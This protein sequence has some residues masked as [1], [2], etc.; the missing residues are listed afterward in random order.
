MKS[1]FS[2]VLGSAYYFDVK[3]I[4]MNLSDYVYEKLTDDGV[5][6]KDGQR[7]RLVCPDCGTG[8][9]S[10]KP[11]KGWATC[12][13]PGCG[14]KVRPERNYKHSW[15]I[16]FLEVLHE[17]WHKFLLSEDGLDFRNLLTDQREIYPALI[18]HLPIGVIP[19]NYDLSRAIS[20][21]RSSMV[22]D[23]S[24]FSVEELDEDD[25]PKSQETRGSKI[26]SQI[27]SASQ[28]KGHSPCSSSSTKRAA[29][30]PGSM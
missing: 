13:H 22:M 19:P 4:S 16:A 7:E 26:G 18:G 21:A 10:V 2:R 17:D 15:V 8:H 5:V 11:D 9:L 1:G 24:K 27:R 28:R 30:S 3:G 23:E 12:W 29:G 6:Y 20:A 14:Y 25:R